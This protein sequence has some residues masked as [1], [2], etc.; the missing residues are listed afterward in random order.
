MPLANR[1]TKNSYERFTP[2]HH[3]LPNDAPHQALLEASTLMSGASPFEKFTIGAAALGL[4]VSL[5]IFGIP[6]EVP[7]LPTHTTQ[8]L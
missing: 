6:P 5:S 8:Q 3:E 4:A 2:L 7:Q 1:P